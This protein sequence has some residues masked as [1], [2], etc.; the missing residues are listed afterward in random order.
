MEAF[1]I[2]LFKE[3]ILQ[4]SNYGIL[5]ILGIITVYVIPK[6]KKITKK[7]ETIEELVL[8]IEEK[9]EKVDKNT[10][11]VQKIYIKQQ[12]DKIISHLE[13]IYTLSNNIDKNLEKNIQSVLI[14]LENILRDVEKTIST[15]ENLKVE[16]NEALKKISYSVE[17][18][19]ELLIKINIVLE[20]LRN[21]GGLR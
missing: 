21:S 14:Q 8:K 18:I 1:F 20:P 2:S 4:Y 17:K 10:G 6:S 15:S 5:I 12:F 7:I 3:I 16:N 9:L 19:Q 11:E 13:N